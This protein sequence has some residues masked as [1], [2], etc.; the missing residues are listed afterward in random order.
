MNYN[1]RYI[2]FIKNFNTDKLERRKA[3]CVLLKQ[4]PKSYRIRLVDATYDRKPDDVLWVRKKS[5]IRSY[6]NNETGM[7]DIYNLNPAE[8][9]CRACLQ[10]CLKRY[11]LNRQPQSY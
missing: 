7:C 4:T 11:E 1:G 9:S 5:V 2:Y 3:R 8:Q 6:L 10:K